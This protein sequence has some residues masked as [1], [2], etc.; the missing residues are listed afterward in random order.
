MM[1]LVHP[2]LESPSDPIPYARDSNPDSGITNRLD[3]WRTATSP[4]PPYAPVEIPREPE[5][6][7]RVMIGLIEMQ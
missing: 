2:T 3:E 6:V 1:H 4:M 7:P 5:I